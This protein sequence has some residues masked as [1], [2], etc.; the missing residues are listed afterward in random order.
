MNWFEKV[1]RYYDMGKY[2][3]EQV[4][5]FVQTGKITEEE[6][7]IITNQHIVQ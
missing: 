5:V 1:K 6:F 3:V 7:K 2:T 4:K